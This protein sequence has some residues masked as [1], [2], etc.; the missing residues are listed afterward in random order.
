MHSL[1]PDIA[2][3][4]FPL[5]LVRIIEP[6][7]HTSNAQRIKE[8]KVQTNRDDAAQRVHTAR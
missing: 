3:V 8:S 6:H 5:T 7:L 1:R 2:W 4:L